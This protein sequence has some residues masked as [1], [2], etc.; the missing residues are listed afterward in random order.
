MSQGLMSGRY[1]KPAPKLPAEAESAG[2]SFQRGIPPTMFKALVGHGHAEFSTMRQ[3]DAFEFLEFF[4]KQLEQKERPLQLSTTSNMDFIVTERLQCSQCQKVRLRDVTYSSLQLP[5]PATAAGVNEKGETTYLPVELDACFASIR[6]EEGVDGFRCPNCNNQPVVAMKSQRLKTFPPVLILHAQ[7]F[8]LENWVPKK[9]NV[10]ITMTSES[11]DL[12]SLKSPWPLPG[13]EMLAEDAPSAGASNEPQVDEQH[14]GQL[15]SM[16]F[17]RNRAMRALVATQHAGAEVA[18]EWLFSKMD[19][20]SL[21]APLEPQ[22]VASNSAP[23]APAELVASLADMGFTAAQAKKALRE[24][25]NNM[26]R[27]VEWLF[28]H[29][30][31][32]GDNAAAPAS[33][34]NTKV[35]TAR[36]GLPPKYRLHSVIAHKG[37]GVHCGHY[38]TYIYRPEEER[39]IL[40]NDEKVVEQPNGLQ[41]DGVQ[42][43]YIYVMVNEGA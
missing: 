26:E 38:V 14:V 32:P 43:G 25:Q 35:T 20:P 19:D 13:D 42:Q 22:P 30:E 41:S 1:S 40:F 11:V 36:E 2:E 18:M 33:S 6:I 37:T 23:E 28:S 17:S 12:S 24:T 29:P 3:Q 9:L 5:V 39:W 7:R 21:D 31:D 15:T 16:G 27:A 8:V 4:L 34:S 10:P